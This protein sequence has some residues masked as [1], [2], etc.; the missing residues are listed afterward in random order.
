VRLAGASSAAARVLGRPVIV[1]PTVYPGR[2][3]SRENGRKRL[4]HW[5]FLKMCPLYPE[6]GHSRCLN[7]RR[8]AGERRERV[9]TRQ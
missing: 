4:R 7:N 3:L 5:H 8:A 1:Y 6:S 9:L 2:I